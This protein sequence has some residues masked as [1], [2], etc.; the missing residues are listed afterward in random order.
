MMIVDKVT[1]PLPTS[2]HISPHIHYHGWYQAKSLYYRDCLKI[3]RLI[4]IR[5]I[6]LYQG[7]TWSVHAST[8]SDKTTG[9]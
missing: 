5:W 1:G 7:L 4:E 2:K 6:N 8:V 3:V 9:S